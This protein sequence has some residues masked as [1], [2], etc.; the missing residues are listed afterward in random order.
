VVLPPN[1]QFTPVEKIINNNND[2]SEE[3]MH[4]SDEGQND[5]SEACSIQ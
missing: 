5:T 1:T 2:G 3:D 4:E